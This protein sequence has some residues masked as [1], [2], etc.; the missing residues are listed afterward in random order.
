MN[1]IGLLWKNHLCLWKNHLCLL[2]GSN[3]EDPVKALTQIILYNHRIQ[4]RRR[5]SSEE[6]H[7]QH[8]ADKESPFLLYID[9]K[10]F[11][12]TR[13]REIID[14]LHAQGLCVSYQRILRIT[15][16]LGEALLQIFH[17]DNAEVLR[18]LRTGLFTVAAK[19]KIDKNS[20]C[21]ISKSHYHVISMSLFQ[22]PSSS[23]DRFE[24]NYQ[25]FDRVPSSKSKKVGEPLS[26]YTDV[27]KIADP[28]QAYY[29]TK[30]PLITLILF[31]S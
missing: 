20:R 23:N 6:R 24:R 13:S 29:F 8:N 7:Q 12:A 28:S 10:V 26:F 25:Q 1:L 17:D 9:L 15:Q 5:E 19:Y 14:I 21:T 30:S 22:F 4:G 3:H 18:I 31:L 11:L 27:E 16:G 2:N